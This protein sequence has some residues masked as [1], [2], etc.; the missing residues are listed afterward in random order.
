M[1]QMKIIS[2]LIN[3]DYTAVLNFSSIETFLRL[4]LKTDLRHISFQAEAA[5]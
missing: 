2:R 5:E 3:L 1:H 4:H